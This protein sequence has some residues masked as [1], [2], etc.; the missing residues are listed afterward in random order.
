MS[1]TIAGVNY[2]IT[3][4][5]TSTNTVT[6]ATAPADGSVTVE[7]GPTR[8][9]GSS[10]SARLRKVS[11]FVPVVGGDGSGE[12]AIMMDNMDQMQGHRHGADAVKGSSTSVIYSIG[13]S[14]SDF[15]VMGSTANEG[16]VSAKH[17]VQSP[18]TDTVNGAPRTGKTTNPRTHGVGAYTYLGV[19]L[20]TTWTS[21]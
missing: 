9:A 17:C 19:L 2:A 10:T 15:P 1:V 16:V 12:V 6:L 18:S 21:A 20:E 14:S 11:G 13:G 8:I 7:V 3:N 4:V 5:V